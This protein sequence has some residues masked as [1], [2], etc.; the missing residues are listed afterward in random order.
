MKYKERIK[1]F[2][3]Q[4]FD[5]PEEQVVLMLPE[6]I[7]AL[8]SHIEQLEKALQGND[9]APLITAGHTIKGAFLNLG[10]TECAEIALQ[11]EQGSRNSDNSK[12][13]PALVA[14]LSLIVNG[15]INE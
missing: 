3:G 8:S 12:D 15:I 6:F 1:T 13:Y 2:L 5:F 11:I 10:L 7:G 14:S 4:R 9:L